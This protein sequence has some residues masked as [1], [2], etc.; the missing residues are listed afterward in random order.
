LRLIK[1]YCNRLIWVDGE[2]HLIDKGISLGCPLSPLISALYLKKLDK[3]LSKQKVFYRRF[4]D[5]WVVLAKT[6]NHLRKAVKTAEKILTQLQLNIHPDKTF[7][8]CITKGFEFLGYLFKPEG[9]QISLKTIHRCYVKL[10]QLYEQGASRI[11]IEQYW[12]KWQRWVVSGLN[13]CIR[14]KF[15]G[16]FH[17]RP[18][19]SILKSNIC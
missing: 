18:T 8:G 2:Y 1:E 3:A 6:R 14:Y 19:K 13:D 17:N 11:R 5:D 16:L 7:I 10:I 15:L 12:Q 4:M 9:L